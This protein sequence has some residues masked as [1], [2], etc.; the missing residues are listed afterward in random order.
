MDLFISHYVSRPCSPPIRPSAAF[1][2]DSAGIS[3]KRERSAR[4]SPTPS[5]AAKEEE[6]ACLSDDTRET[7]REKKRTFEGRL[8]RIEGP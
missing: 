4:S 1:I 5:E 3:P 6:D 2:V 7:S 8:K